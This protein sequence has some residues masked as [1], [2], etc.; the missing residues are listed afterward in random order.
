MRSNASQFLGRGQAVLLFLA[1]L[2]IC[3]LAQRPALSE[4][5]KGAF[6]FPPSSLFDF[7]DTL[8]KPAGG[9]GFLTVGR[10]EHFYFADGSRAR[11]W[12]INVSSTRLNIPPAQIEQVVGN[13]ARA[14]LNLVRLEAIDNHNCLLGGPDAPDSRHFDAHYLDCLDHWM[15]SLR[16]HGIYYY[17]DLLDFRTFKSGDGVLNA[18]S[19]DRGARPYAIFDRYLIQLQKEYAGKLLTHMN[20]YSHLRPVD[21]PALAM[22]EIC[23]EHGFFLYPEKLESLVEP[24]RS[25]LKARWNAWLSS[26]Y[27]TRENLAATWGNLNGTPILGPAENFAQNSID[28]PLLTRPSGNTAP[29]PDIRR[30]PLRR[31]DGVAFL[32]EVQRAWFREMRAYAQSLGLRVPV[33]A[34]VSSDVI[35]DVASVAQECDF[36]A[37]NWY[38][39]SGSDTTTAGVIRY[40]SNRNSLFDETSGG[41]APYTAA[42]RWNNKPVVIREWAVPWPN[43]YRASSVP[44]T[45]AY[46][47]LQNIDAVLLFGYQTNRSPN[48]AEA[49]ALNDF[50]FQ[51]DPS[52]WGLYALAGQ[53]FRSYA[54]RA[55]SPTVTLAYP[56]GR[57]LTW[58]NPLT[59][60]HRLA[61]CTALGAATE[62]VLGSLKSG[63]VVTPT[64]TPDDLRSLHQILAG[65]GAKA[66]P[67]IEKSFDSGVFRSV[68]GQIVCYCRNGHLE[69]RAPRIRALAGELS[70]GR[71]YSL[72][73]FQISTAT[74]IAAVMAW[75]LDR[76]PI[77]LSHHLVI[78]MVS[79]AENTGEIFER[80]PPN[81]LGEWALRGFGSSPVLTFGRPF[82]RPTRIWLNRT[83]PKTTAARKVANSAGSKRPG[84]AGQT[85]PS[86][87]PL[88]TLFMVDGTWEIEINDDVV[89][90]ACD[91]SGI[92]GQLE[93]HAFTTTG[94]PEPLVAE[95]PMD[96]RAARNSTRTR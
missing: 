49:D 93:G 53:A 42:L 92:S 55:A 58:P 16:R 57:R 23:N 29:T 68:T 1:A 63:T 27:G 40:Y 24:Y 15:D 21:D 9:H 95:K 75:S 12:G 84:G 5:S 26:R 67:G 66:A 6:H 3:L 59:D 51:A 34:V 32:V 54:I 37:E 28:L 4:T 74:P 30:A 85:S 76:K 33:T 72:G 91:T 81:P 89:T 7:T 38:A 48:G 10:D 52:V 22:V 43:R 19:L 11:F 83:T 71:I 20:P 88:L 14:G 86:E 2:A 35:P 56:L 39:D 62:D 87:R 82:G 41:I 25:D 44:Q 61:W 77:E 18:D 80:A 31:R 64:G 45:L 65:L 73:G 13:F 50:A 96:G 69:I 46:A 79:R 94:L 70:P 78:K 90:F 36:T 8:E 17:L 60:L 47:S